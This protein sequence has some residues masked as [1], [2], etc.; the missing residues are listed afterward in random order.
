MYGLYHTGFCHPLYRLYRPGFARVPRGGDY[1]NAMSG[2]PC[3]AFAAL[4][5]GL[6]AVVPNLTAQSPCAN[7]PAY[8]TCEMV[9]ELSEAD[10]AA[11]SNPYGNV[12]LTAQFR[13]PRQH[14]FSQPAFWDGGR[15]MVI[16]FAPTEAGEWVYR[17]ASNIAAWDGQTGSFTAA[18]SDAP[19]FIRAANVHHW[20]YTER[21]LPHLW[22]GATERGLATLEEDSF[23]ALADARAAQKFNHVRG[24]VLGD[25]PDSGYSSPDAPDLARFRRLEE[26][27]RYLNQKGIVADLIL[28]GTP[29]QLTRLFPGRDDR[30]RFIRYVVGRLAAFNVTWQGVERFEDSLDGRAVMREIG[31]SLKET[32]P[33]QHPRTSGARITSAPLLDDHWMDFAAYGTA[34][35]GVGAIEHQ[36]YPVPFVN[37]DFGREDSGAGKTGPDDVDTATFRHRLW[38]ATM[39]GQ[40]V[41]YANT[42]SGAPYANA[43]GA[44]QM[45]VWFDVLSDTRHWELEPYFDVDGGRAVALEDVDYLVYIEKPGPVELRVEKHGYDVLWINPIDGEITRRKFSGDHFT[46]EPPDK[47]HD[48]VLHVVRESRV[49]SMNRSF[50]FE[51]R[52]I[53]LQEI[54]SNTGKV[55]FAIEQ[56]AGDLKVGVPAV[57]SAKVTRETRA[58]RSMMWLWIGEVPADG[59][60]YRVLATG[61]QGS[62]KVPAGV[63]R[64]FPV[65][66]SLRL[67]GMN[68]NGKVYALDKAYQ[69]TR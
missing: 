56:P 54:D 8:S 52:D 6:P 12:D 66:M 48:W 40:Y 53:V 59:Q 43:P 26:R 34:D 1:T 42:G 2:K 67:Y 39:D 16:R 11:H 55:P 61:Q 7:T 22:M 60:G 29:A 27:V 3:F 33:F 64:D 25:G 41:T 36:L 47:S 50:K 28:A 31:T 44:R 38:N 5:A 49:E 37:L 46:G 14:T 30:R 35:D 24:L 69:V 17:L 21:N 9:F 4:L 19:G 62:L 15:R 51:S 68:G 45:S 20:A 10:A 63:A 23:R 57:F 65:V 32:D 18:A 13:S 58:T